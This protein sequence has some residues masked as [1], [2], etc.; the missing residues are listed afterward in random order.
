MHYPNKYET[1]EKIEECNKEIYNIL[2]Q[3]RF[4]SG[5]LIAEQL[6]LAFYQAIQIQQTYT[7]LVYENL[8]AFQKSDYDKLQYYKN[9][10]I[11]LSNLNHH[12]KIEL[13]KLR[14]SLADIDL[15]GLIGIGEEHK[16]NVIQ[17]NRLISMLDK[18]IHKATNKQVKY[19]TAYNKLQ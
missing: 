4:A 7:S 14:S 18:Q 9:L 12:K 6:R 13:I 8:G 10:C 3:D 11:T 19:F 5:K 1:I 2:S 16:E 15:R 17:L